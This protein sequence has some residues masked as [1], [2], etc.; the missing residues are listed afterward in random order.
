MYEIIYYESFKENYPVF[1]FISS[2]TPQRTERN[3]FTSEVWA[4]FRYASFTKN[5]KYKPLGA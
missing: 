2:Q 5:Q 3:R 4:I 1:E